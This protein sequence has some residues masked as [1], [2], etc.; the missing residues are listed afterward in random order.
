MSPGAIANRQ[1]PSRGQPAEEKPQ[2]LK[3]ARRARTEFSVITG[4]ECNLVTTAS[5]T[6]PDLTHNVGLLPFLR[7]VFKD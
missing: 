3:E 5:K 6:W 4:S 2:P 1:T 7:A